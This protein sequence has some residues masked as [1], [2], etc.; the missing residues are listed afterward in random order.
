LLEIQPDVLGHVNGGPTSLSDEGSKSL[1]TEGGTMALQLVQAG[2]L[3]AAIHIAEAALA[4]GCPQRL[5]IA[6]DTPTGT[7]MIPLALLRSMA[8]LV[9]L[10]PLTPEQAIAAVTGNVS[11]TYSLSAGMLRLGAPAD[12][13]VIDAPLGSTA[14]DWRQALRI[15]DLPSVAVAVTDGSVRFTR[16]R[17]TPPPKRDVSMSKGLAVSLPW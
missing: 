2:N 10:G 4:A 16:S 15:G 13:L 3:R 7:G 1:V 5:L 11:A 6:S 12:L 17:N 8:E 14:A 9:S